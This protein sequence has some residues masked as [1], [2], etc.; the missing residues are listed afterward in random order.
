MCYSRALRGYFKLWDDKEIITVLE[1]FD[2][3][4]AEEV[5][6]QYVASCGYLSPTIDPFQKPP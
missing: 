4:V 2:I 5:N 6:E 3:K 1:D